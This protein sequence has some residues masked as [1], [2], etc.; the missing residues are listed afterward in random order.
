M[1]LHYT[2]AGSRYQ[3]GR[4]GATGGVGHPDPDSARGIAM[5]ASGTELDPCLRA[6]VLA[7]VHPGWVLGQAEDLGFGP[8]ELVR[9]AGILA[10]GRNPEA[11]M[12]LALGTLRHWKGLRGAALAR[13][14]PLLAGLVGALPLPHGHLAGWMFGNGLER[15]PDDPPWLGIRARALRRLGHPRFAPGDRNEA[16]PLEARR[17]RAWLDAGHSLVATRLAWRGGASGAAEWGPLLVPEVVLRDG[18]VPPVLRWTR[19][20]WPARGACVRLFRVAGLREVE[21]GFTRVTLVA[22]GCPD[23]VRLRGI[24]WN[25]VARD[26]PRLAEVTVPDSGNLV[27]LERCP[28]LRSL[29]PGIAS[30]GPEFDR[31]PPRAALICRT[32]VLADCPDLRTLPRELWVQGS[33]TLRRMGPF[34]AWPD[35]FRVD[36]DLR[37]RDCERIEELPPVQVGGSLRVQGDSGLRRLRPGSTVGGDLDLRACARL[38]GLPPDLEPAGNLLL[39]EHLRGRRQAPGPVGPD[40][41]TTHPVARRTPH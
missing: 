19:V 18:R 33:M 6:L 17:A 31:A 24:F 26:C 1:S 25:L 36:G 37:I 13:G 16:T 9:I 14:L 4:Q 35:P 8:G 41:G 10:P 27:H 5:A 39:P 2:G 21:H 32:L 29:E 12:A 20:W 40:L 7:G 38:E 11:G 3:P 28:G 15:L 30:R 34:A 22:R 23:L